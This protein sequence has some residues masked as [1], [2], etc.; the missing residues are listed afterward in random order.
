MRQ[1]VVGDGIL[2]QLSLS[3]RLCHLCETMSTERVLRALGTLL[4]ALCAL[5]GRRC[6]RLGKRDRRHVRCETRNANIVVAFC[7]GGM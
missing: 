3:L 1:W 4:S 7:V 5:G 6:A 2:H